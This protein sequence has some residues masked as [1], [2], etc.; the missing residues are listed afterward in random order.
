MRLES[1][2]TSAIRRAF[3]IYHHV[4]DALKDVLGAE[5]NLVDLWAKNLF[6]E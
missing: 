6:D 5:E 1:I 2:K 4:K 3:K